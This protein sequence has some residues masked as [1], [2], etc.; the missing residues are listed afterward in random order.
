MAAPRLPAA[1]RP[2]PRP[3]REQAA[4][5]P[6]LPPAVA[7][8]LQTLVR[9]A[10]GGAAAAAANPGLR[11]GRPRHPHRPSTRAPQAGAAAGPRARA[12][13]LACIS[14]FC[15]ASTEQHAAAVAAPGLV[16]VVA[17][18][19][20]PT[21]T[22][23]GGDER[24]SEAEE[25]GGCSQEDGSSSSSS[26]STDCSSDGGSG[27]SPRG[28]PAELRAA[29]AALEA[30]ADLAA[31]APGRTA[32]LRAGGAAALCRLLRQWLLPRALAVGSSGSDEGARQPPLP[33]EQLDGQA[34]RPLKRRRVDAPDGSAA[35]GGPRAAG[36]R[37]LGRARALRL[38]G[39][40]A[41]L[42]AELLLCGTSGPRLGALAA[43]AGLG[44][45]HDAQVLTEGLAKVGGV[46]GGGGWMGAAVPRG[47]WPPQQASSQEADRAT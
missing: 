4:E 1:P 3:Q 46:V 32:L 23:G 6:P 12:R 2:R 42:L 7:R 16:D 37:P 18:H 31:S 14:S 10:G 9:P 41:C 30:A 20:C 39:C 21:G 33:P 8:A 36:T 47:P 13:A 45:P 24:S 17:R 43:A 5:P 11:S 40:V 27:G 22:P 19:L 34:A 38:A 29:A 35:A 26:S 25:M 28:P 15:L 44:E